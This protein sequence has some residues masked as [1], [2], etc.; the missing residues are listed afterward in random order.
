[1]QTASEEIKQGQRF[2]FG[3]NWQ[4]FLRAVNEERVAEAERSLRDMLEVEN[5]SGKSFLDVG[6]GSGLFSLAAMRLAARRV[7]SFDYDPQSVAC[8]LE[9]KRRYFNEDCDWTI[10]EGNVLDQNYL[11]GLGEFDIVYS[12]GVLHHTG[13]MWKALE[14]IVPLVAKGGR[15]FV[16]I[17]NAQVYWT[18]L[19]RGLKRT[20]TRSPQVVKK[21]IL[22]CFVLVQALKGLMKDLL[23]FRNP[24]RRYVDKEKSRGMSTFCD[25]IDWLGGYP[26]EVAKPEDIFEFFKKRGFHLAKLRTCGGGFGNNQYVFV[27]C[28]E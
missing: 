12:W 23:F 8:T 11:R 25:W 9:L 14:N 4:R 7:R 13:N 18:P 15:L 20:Y 10:E 17:Y 24:V 6:S 28:A 21:M 1:M 19:W 27:K 16:A 22:S 5:L 26:F 3:K 2:E